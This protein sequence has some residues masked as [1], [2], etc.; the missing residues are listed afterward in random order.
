MTEALPVP[1]PP[2]HVLEELEPRN[3]VHRYF[4]FLKQQKTQFCADCLF[5]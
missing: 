5:P 4:P 2:A 1:P 3:A